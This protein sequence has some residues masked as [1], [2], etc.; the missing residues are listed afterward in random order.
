VAGVKVFPAVMGLEAMAQAAMA[1]ADSEQP[2]TLFEDVAFER[3]V[4]LGVLDDTRTIRIAALLTAP[5][6]VELVIRSDETDFQVDHFRAT[7]RF[8]PSAAAQIGAGLDM[9]ADDGQATRIDADDLYATIFYQQGAFKRVA[10]YHE[11][12]ATRVRAEIA[13]DGETRWFGGHMPDDLVLGDPGARDAAIHAGQILAPHVVW[14]P[15]RVERIVLAPGDGGPIAVSEIEEEGGAT[16]HED[17]VA[18]RMADGGGAVRESW[19]RVHCRVMGAGGRNEDWPAALFA[20]YLQRRV[21]QLER[22][23]VRVALLEDAGVD[24]ESDRAIRAA[25]GAPVAVRRRPDGK[26]EAS[27]GD[28]VSLSHDAGL[29]LAIAGDGRVGCDLQ[30]VAQRDDETWRGMLGGERHRLARALADET[31][32]PAD[33]AATRVWS[34]TECLTKAG[35]RPDGPL[36]LG[37]TTPDG[38]VPLDTGGDRVLTW[39]SDPRGGDGAVLVFAVLV[40]RTEP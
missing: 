32:E 24:G 5:D 23:P 13:P 20:P 26:P 21:W 2:P 25:V 14:I 11:V 1:L 3:P 4:V 39:A 33:I 37:E 34:A 10:N 40:G 7:C 30:A 8:D 38:W 16:E 27:N 19:S 31:G 6:T 9:P 36:T 29:L 12:A 17:V 18:V 22:T 28:G 35:G 15:T